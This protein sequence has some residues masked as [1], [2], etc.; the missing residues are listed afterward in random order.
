M[1]TAVQNPTSSDGQPAPEFP[2]PSRPHAHLANRKTIRTRIRDVL[3][4]LMTNPTESIVGNPMR[5]A[6]GSLK[7]YAYQLYATAVTWVALKR[8]E[9]LYVEVAEDYA[10]V[11]ADALIGTQVKN[12]VGSGAIT[13]NSPAVITA[14]N[15]FVEL[16]GLNPNHQVHLEYLTTS[17]STVEKSKA[18]RIKNNGGIR[19]WRLASQ[20][21]AIGPLKSRL[22]SLDISPKC[23]AFIESRNDRQL[24]DDMIRKIHWNCGQPS[25]HIL[26]ENLESILITHGESKGVPSDASSVVA[27]IMVATI[28]EIATTTESRQLRRS[29]FLKLFDK[30]TS[31][32][33]PYAQYQELIQPLMRVSYD[34]K[35][36][37]S[38]IPS[39][40][41]KI[42]LTPNMNQL[43]PRRPKLTQIVGI[44]RHH[45]VAWLFGGVGRGKTTLA[46]KVAVESG[47]RWLITRY[48]SL[49]PGKTVDTLR[50]SVT[51]LVLSRPH[52]IILDDLNEFAIPTVRDA[53][54]RL[55]TTAKHTGTAVIVTA[56]HKP[57]VTLCTEMGLLPSVLIEVEN[58]SQADIS[59]LVQQHGASPQRWTRYIW[60]ASA[61]G[62]PRLAHALTV[63]FCGRQWPDSE[64]TTL[65]ALLGQN[66]DV[67][68]IRVE[69]RRRLFSELPDRDRRFLYRL[70]SL[71]GTFDRSTAIAV[72]GVS[73]S[74]HLAGESLDHL[75][76]PWI[77][78]IGQ[79]EFRISPLLRQASQQTLLQ[80]DL[81]GI[82][83]CVARHLAL[84]D[85]LPSD[86]I[87]AILS[88]ALIGEESSVLVKLSFATM[89]APHQI[90]RAIAKSTIV[91]VIAAT[92]R[93][94]F[95]KDTRI[96]ALLRIQQC[97]LTLS[98]GFYE[99]FGKAWTALKQELKLIKN[100]E[101]ETITTSTAYCKICSHPDLSKAKPEFSD[102][103]LALRPII[104]S[105]EESH[106]SR[107]TSELPATNDPIPPVPFLFALQLMHIDTSQRLLKVFRHIAKLS[108]RDRAYLFQI[109]DH[110]DF[111]KSSSFR[112]V[113]E[114]ELA[115]S[116]PNVSKMVANYRELFQ[117]CIK[118]DDDF[119][120]ESIVQTSFILDE[121]MDNRTGAQLELEDAVQVLGER[122]DLTRSRARVLFN[123]AEYAD[124]LEVLVPILDRDE[125][126]NPIE[127]SFMHREAA[128]AFAY[129][130]RWGRSARHFKMSETFASYSSLDDM[131]VM[132][133]GLSADTSVAYWQ[134]SHRKV[135]VKGMLDVLSRLRQIDPWSGLR[136]SACHRFISHSVAWMN[137]QSRRT[138]EAKSNIKHKMTPGLNSNPTPHTDLAI[139]PTV[140]FDFLYYQLAQIDIRCNLSLD[141]A[142]RLATL[143]SSKGA[144]LLGEFFLVHVRWCRAFE[145]LDAIGFHKQATLMIE[146][147]ATLDEHSNVTL[148]NFATPVRGRIAKLSERSFKNHRRIQLCDVLIFFLWAAVSGEYRAVNAFLEKDHASDRPILE[149]N[150]IQSFHDG[151]ARG[152]G[153]SEYAAAV[154]LMT[155]Q[156]HGD[157]V[158]DIRGLLQCG[159]RLVELSKGSS[160]SALI[161]DDVLEWN[162]VLW[163]DA[164]KK[165]AFRFLAPGYGIPSILSKIHKIPSG[166]RGLSHLLLLVK[167]YIDIKLSH[168]IIREL[169]EI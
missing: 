163:R 44:L 31:I 148:D 122:A 134:D 124:A 89:N 162:V 65:S 55:L 19:Y 95:P 103:L 88:H 68:Q 16:V 119:A 86:R 79:D 126:S 150:V 11:S 30:H 40:L 23:K 116:S 142:N 168:D 127:R 5:Q 137:Q 54:I 113:S 66:D 106:D 27:D 91:G 154:G 166:W 143:L 37:F 28:L 92:D 165:Q 81:K 18:H 136:A 82:H 131:K 123:A 147:A 35:S 125:F 85:V 111:E 144:V 71:I 46:S 8:H 93:L 24:R 141:I 61:F 157:R 1:S 156:K 60:A 12:T 164:M 34:T 155:K 90:V 14:I 53:W 2:P 117:L 152:Q 50:R 98:G 135:S 149:S 120:A 59:E 77:D 13:L 21:A 73:P 167:D 128:I 139:P 10:V 76:G 33:I 48:Y 70:D 114:R 57:S 78:Q 146:A 22:L 159:I 158:L 107:F 75:V 104:D 153:P 84:P 72:G 56:H 100:L 108:T 115:Q 15:Q 138:W 121:F 49:D 129:Q 74:I 140:A 47:D 169:E 51:E 145:S 42:A 97:I 64:C 110:S 112:T 36:E 20:S 69:V 62:H 41:E 25:G 38:T 118:F 101:L 32:S 52:G 63:N 160:L 58:L 39:V 67:E 151:K 6:I 99:K 80:S 105:M 87:D 109:F 43:A 7:G 102:M 161:A 132:A 94:I 9:L 29:D 130:S 3:H 83:R 133:V 4:S 17:E 26:K 96:S 45:Q